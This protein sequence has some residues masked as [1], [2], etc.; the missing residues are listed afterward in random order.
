MQKT[1]CLLDPSMS[2]LISTFILDFHLASLQLQFD[3]N[4]TKSQTLS[5]T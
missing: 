1:Y 3:D 5:S 2:A 4:T